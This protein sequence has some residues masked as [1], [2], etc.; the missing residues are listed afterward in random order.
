MKCPYHPEEDMH[1]VT[2]PLE[3]G[4]TIDAHTCPE[5]EWNP[6]TPLPETGRTC[7]DIDTMGWPTDL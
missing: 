1:P 3:S 4:G 2:V 7:P 6:P 5:C